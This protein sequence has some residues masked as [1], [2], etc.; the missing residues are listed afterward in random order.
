MNLIQRVQA[1][2]LKPKETWPVIAEESAT[3]ASIYGEYVVFLAAIPAIASFVG[4]SIIGAGMFGISYRVPIVSGVVHMV[5]HFVMSLVAVYLMALLVDA[6]APTF[7]GTRNPLNA[8]K[9]VAYGATAGFVG[10]IFSL[11]PALSLLGLLAGLYSI[12]LIYAG[13]PV[14]MKCP[15]ERAGGYTAVVMIIAIVVGVILGAVFGA[16]AGAVGLGYGG[17]GGFTGDGGNMHIKTADGDVTIDAGA[18]GQAA[19][20]ADAARQRMEAAQ[21]S[22]DAAAQGKALGDMM[23]ALAGGGNTNPIDA[24]LLKARLPDAIGDLKR[25]SFEASGGQAMGIAGSSAKASYASGDKRVNLTIT[26]LGG[27]AAVAAMAGWANM[28]VD[29]ET[30]DSIEK[31]YKQDGRTIHEEYRKDGS[32]GEYTVMLQNNVIVEAEG[33]GVD[34]AA[35]KSALAGIDLG[36]L[37]SLKRT[38]KA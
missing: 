1:I 18:I 17:Y 30:Q 28:T 33:N 23:G 32:H 4:L 15:P 3:P 11:L 19:A 8:L 38:P 12:Y 25:E 7:G 10:G 22:G 14:L 35:L 2:L 24:Q 5:L 13:M 21:K 20:R 9:L 34:I 31:V 16:V 27:M 36:G 29:K 37:E 26:D 6:L